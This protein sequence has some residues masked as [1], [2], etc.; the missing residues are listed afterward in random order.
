MTEATIRALRVA[1]TG[2]SPLFDAGQMLAALTAILLSP[3]TG[4][5]NEEDCPAVQTLAKALTK[6]VLAFY[7]HP[8]TKRSMLRLI[9]LPVPSA[10]LWLS[11]TSGYTCPSG[12]SVLQ[13]YEGRQTKNACGDD[14]VKTL[15]A[16]A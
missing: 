13:N 5:A 6:S 15:L 14:E 12:I 11:E 1:A 9:T 8:V 3:I 16:P 7:K 4:T 2:I 10:E